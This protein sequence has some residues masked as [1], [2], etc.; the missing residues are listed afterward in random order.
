MKKSSI[1]LSGDRSAASSRS[2]H[3]LPQP[4]AVAVW[5]IHAWESCSL[6]PRAQLDSAALPQ[7]HLET[8]SFSAARLG[9]ARA[10][11][12]R[13]EYYRLSLSGAKK[14]RKKKGMKQRLRLSKAD[15]SLWAE[16]G[17]CF[18]TQETTEEEEK[19]PGCSSTRGTRN[20]RRQEQRKGDAGIENGAVNDLS[21]LHKVK[22]QGRPCFWFF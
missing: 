5:W 20:R 13:G 9:S 12:H 16:R 17:G 11:Q 10:L 4:E 15:V 19:A 8:E 2:S 3:A 1:W 6:Y 22:R 14:K 18:L 7:T 21:T